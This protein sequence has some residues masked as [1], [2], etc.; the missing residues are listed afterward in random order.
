MYN[1][2]E[3]FTKEI[4]IL[5]QINVEETDI[6]DTQKEDF[7]K[8]NKEVYVFKNN[9]IIRQKE[10]WKKAVKQIEIIAKKVIN[11]VSK[12]QKTKSSTE[13]YNFKWISAEDD[14]Q[15]IILWKEKLWVIKLWKVI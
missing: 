6:C 10:I 3:V 12:S 5:N 8:H 2:T 1:I 14:I 4:A 9:K 11:V 7:P 13:L 15:D